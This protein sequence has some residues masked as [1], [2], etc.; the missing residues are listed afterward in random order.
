M[1]PAR[2][3]EHG[4]HGTCARVDDGGAAAAVAAAAAAAHYT[5]VL[6]Q[7]SISLTLKLTHRTVVQY[8]VTYSKGVVMTM[9]EKLTN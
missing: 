4:D 7:L 6:V 9:H 8:D 5:L 1:R 3:E 2:L